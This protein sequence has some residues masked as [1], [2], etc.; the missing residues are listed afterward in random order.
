[1]FSKF[2]VT[3]RHKKLRVFH[4]KST[5]NRKQSR[6][7][8]VKS[9]V[10]DAGF[11]SQRKPSLFTSSLSRMLTRVCPGENLKF[12]DSTSTPRKR[13][14]LKWTLIECSPTVLRPT[15][16]GDLLVLDG[17]LVVVRDLLVDVDGLSGVDHDLLLRLHCDDLRITVRLKEKT[18]RISSLPSSCSCLI[19]KKSSV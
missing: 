6:V 12:E 8:N 19:H 7:N 17:E 9:A 18:D 2:W 3:G 13:T 11:F 1:M 14:D 16:T 5:I 15:Q 4:F 10:R